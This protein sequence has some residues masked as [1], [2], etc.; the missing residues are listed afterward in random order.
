MH[1]Q[2]LKYLLLSGT[3]VL[4]AAA[5]ASYYQCEAHQIRFWIDT[6]GLNSMAV[7]N[8]TACVSGIY[9]AQL[10]QLS[11]I[12]QCLRGQSKQVVQCTLPTDA[13][14]KA[15]VIVHTCACNAVLMLIINTL[16]VLISWVQ[17]AWLQ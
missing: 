8:G 6:T 4:T 13:Q 12:A 16:A 17:G 9:A 15:T 5:A 14:H 2:H 11:C 1:W 7:D 10:P 3:L